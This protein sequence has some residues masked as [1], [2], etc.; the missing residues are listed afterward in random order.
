MISAKF[1]KRDYI[2]TILIVICIITF[3]LVMLIP[4]KTDEAELTSKNDNIKVSGNANVKFVCTFEKCNHIL[5]VEN[6][7]FEGMTE[8]DILEKYPDGRIYK[9]SEDE[10]R[11]SRHINDYCPKHYVLK[12]DNN[13]LIVSRFNQD[14]LE[15]EYIMELDAETL[16]LDSNINDINRGDMEFDSLVAINEYIEGIEN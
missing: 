7:S 13:K 15:K 3:A 11:I 14:T 2:F 1:G 12:A 16:E 8:K 6:V 4:D 5:N 9:F 10:I